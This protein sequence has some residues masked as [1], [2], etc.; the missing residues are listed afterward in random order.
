MLFSIATRVQGARHAPSSPSDLVNANGFDQPQLA[1]LRRRKMR[2]AAW[3]AMA[4]YLLV[5]AIVPPGHMAAALASGTA[6]HLCPGDLRSAQLLQVFG[7]HG[8]G[9]SHEGGHEGDH[10]RALADRHGAD[11]PHEE[12]VDTP[13][14][15]H[16][17]HHGTPDARSHAA[18]EAYGLAQ[19]QDGASAL[20]DALDMG[21]ADAGC[22]LASGAVVAVDA[23]AFSPDLPPAGEAPRPPSVRRSPLA[24]RWLRPPVRSPPL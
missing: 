6:F 9:N 5:G 10:V 1:L 20:A 2:S 22:M 19:H 18:S 21:S 23:S 4:T 17:D 15:R 11:D 3:L 16:A 24:A 12:P 8:A 14:G 7:S 13:T